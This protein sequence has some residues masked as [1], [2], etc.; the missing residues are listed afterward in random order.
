MVTIEPANIPDELQER[1]QWLLWDADNSTPRQ[2]H[3]AGDFSISWTDPDDWHT[4]EEAVEHASRI[5]SWGIGYVMA[6]D[7]HDHARGLYG[8]LDLDGVL[9]EGD[10]P[11][12]WLPSLERFIADGAYIERSPSGDGLHIPLVGQP[13]PDWWADSHLSADKH[14]GVEYLRNKFCTFTGDVFRPD[15]LEPDGVAETN[16][17]PFL[18]EAYEALN[19]ESPRLDA[20][21]DDSHSDRE[22]TEDD[23]QELLDHVSSACPYPQ[24]RNILFAV[25]D[26]DDGTTGKALAESWSRGSGWDEQSQRLIDTIWQGAEPGNGISLGT[27]VHH[28]KQGGWEPSQG[29]H[30]TPDTPRQPDSAEDIDDDDEGGAVADLS[31]QAVGRRAGL[32]E[33]GGISDL[34]DREKAACVWALVAESDEFHVRVRRDNGSLW[35]YDDGVWKPEGDRALRHAARQALGSMNYGQ[36]V[37]AELKAQARSDPRV[38]VEA[39]EFGLAPGT[40]AVENGLV[41]LDAAADGAGGDALRELEPDDHALTRLP[42]EYDPD[43]T[44]DEWADYVDEWAEDGYADALQEY[45]GYCLHIGEIPIHRAMLLVGSGANGKG[46]FLSVVRAL[47]GRENTSSIELQT[48]AN[49]KDAVADFYGSL[50]NI[51]DDL[52]AR[53]L[54]NGLGMF[55]KLVA[56]D[57]VRARQLYEE[58]F[59]FD[60]VGKHLY[61]ANEVPQVDV[62]DDDEAFWRR[63]LL[64]EFPNHYPPSERDPGLRDRLTEAGVLSGVL[65]WAIDGWDRLLDQGHFTGEERYAQAKRER[66]QAWGDSIDKFVS[67]CVE[68]DPD[69]ENVSTGE[70]HRVYA[71][72]CREHDERPA[73]Q[74]KLTVALKNEDLGYAKRVRPGGTGTPGTGFKTLGFTDDAPDIDDTPERGSGQQQLG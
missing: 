43:A 51:D 36:N 54:G 74:Q 27:L 62:A 55:K 17:A 65:N 66:W 22:W 56:G 47:L 63:W 13:A 32:G 34:D 71:A 3:W 42:V 50:A 20:E 19:G 58:G 28:A 8:C 49:E 53:K 72:W 16:P 64:V 5:D 40:I 21:T 35:A 33:D 30:E 60:A 68:C 46:T 12:D 24:W 52:S 45:V 48:L 11:A 10:H 18:F 14:E 59:E 7:N 67:E 1:D 41:Y 6:G 73:S 26:W 31:P 38:E 61:A 15:E 2:P 23:V 39:D 57:R 4:F 44:A 69:A 9:G 25:H 29:G 37:L 70:V